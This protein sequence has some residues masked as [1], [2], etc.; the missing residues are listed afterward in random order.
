MKLTKQ[1]PIGIN[2]GAGVSCGGY[3]CG[4]FNINE[5]KEHIK[6]NPDLYPPGSTSTSINTTSANDVTAVHSPA[7]N[8]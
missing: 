5:C 4:N 3:P 1:N 7:S 6:A 8:T 2:G